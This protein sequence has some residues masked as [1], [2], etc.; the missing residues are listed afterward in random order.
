MSG[1]THGLYSS[2]TSNFRTR[3][4]PTGSFVGEVSR[5]TSSGISAVFSV[6]LFYAIAAFSGWSTVC[7]LRRVASFAHL[8]W[9]RLGD[10]SKRSLQ[11]RTA[12]VGTYL[13]GGMFWN[14]LGV[15]SEFGSRL[16][17]QTLPNP[18]Y[19][20]A[21]VFDG[22]HLLYVLG[23]VSVPVAFNGD[24]RRSGCVVDS[25]DMHRQIWAAAPDMITGRF[26]FGACRVGKE[27]LAIGGI[28]ASTWDVREPGRR[29]ILSCIDVCDLT[30]GSWQPRNS[31][32]CRRHD[33]ALAT[34]A[35]R[36]YVL[37]GVTRPEGA[38]A[39]DDGTLR[40][41]DAVEVISEAGKKIRT[42][43]TMPV[44]VW[45]SIAI[46]VGRRILILGGSSCAA[47]PEPVQ[48]YD[49]VTENW[50]I[51]R[52]ALRL[53]PLGE[54]FCLVSGICVH[55]GSCVRVF[56]GST[57]T[58]KFLGEAIFDDS[59]ETCE[60]RGC[61]RWGFAFGVAVPLCSC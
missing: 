3:R 8:S 7:A 43:P 36:T 27:V 57:V 50:T 46:V 4:V 47:S 9:T 31:L 10:R 53:S 59:L 13:N 26:D 60:V 34:V 5:Y 37:G 49:T 29:N 12:I 19:Q 21:C 11:W 44:G 35:S 33:F 15:F 61:S 16:Q 32:D 24:L 1:H 14:R 52:P 58:S 48:E 41:C 18:R 25:F 20:P 56:G 45:G 40:T 42:C 38:S 30:D 51:L 54:P 17:W 39:T 6:D 23:G 55:T 28:C 22:S 2:G